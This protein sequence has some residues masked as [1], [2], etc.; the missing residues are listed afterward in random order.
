MGDQEHVTEVAKDNP[1][2]G[3]IMHNS[4]TQMPILVWNASMQFHIKNINQDNLT[5][6]LYEKCLFKPDGKFS[7]RIN[8]FYILN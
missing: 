4:G 1:L 7:I 2:N 5:I 3:N 8:Y 6:T